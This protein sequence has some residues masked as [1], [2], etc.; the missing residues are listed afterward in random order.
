MDAGVLAPCYL[1]Q[2]QLWELSEASTESG[3]VEWGQVDRP[4][5]SGT[6]CHA[7]GSRGCLGYWTVMW[8]RQ[9]P[10]C[11]VVALVLSWC[12]E[13]EHNGDKGQ[14]FK[15][16]NIEKIWVSLLFLIINMY[17]WFYTIL[18]LRNTRV[19]YLHWNLKYPQ[20]LVTVWKIS[21][22]NKI[23]TLSCASSGTI[24]QN[25][26]YV[27]EKSSPSV[28]VCRHRHLVHIQVSISYGH[29]YAA[30]LYLLFSSFRH[31][32]CSLGE[33]FWKMEDHFQ[34]QV[35]AQIP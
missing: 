26:F 20:C 16:C 14:I 32:C 34:L 4:A 6:A 27:I 2:L 23:I 33:Y 12:L 7:P 19:D 9:R 1:N 13:L 3:S 8:R 15:V 17:Y 11:N 29:Y 28:L 10:M 35:A 18:G 31:L 24:H 22:K 5:I 21:L 30:L 25:Y